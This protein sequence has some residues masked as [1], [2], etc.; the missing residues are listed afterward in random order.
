MATAAYCKR[1]DS[2]DCRCLS[3]GRIALHGLPP[4]A[5][6][7]ET[8]EVMDDKIMR[9]LE[10]EG[11]VEPDEKDDSHVERKSAATQLV[12]IATELYDFGVSDAGET[13]AVPKAG[14]RVLF[15][16]RGGKSSLRAQLSREFFTRTGK[17][18]PQQALADA[19][20][21]VEGMAQEEPESRLYLRVARH[22]GALWL[23]LGDNT[24]RAVKI[25]GDGWTVEKE[26]PVL[27]KRTSLTGPLPV[28]VRGGSLDE[29][30]EW[31]NVAEKDRPLIAAH[32][33]AVLLP[34]IPHVVPLIQ[35]EQ[36]T[37][38]STAEKVLVLVLDPSP[39]PLRK[40]P[41]DVDAWVTAAAGSWVVGL[42]NLSDI[43]PW[44][45]DAICRAVT[46]DGDVRRKLYTDG[47]LAVFAFRRVVI[48]NGIDLGALR[49]DLSDRVLPIDL[50]L[51]DEEE[52]IDEEDLWPKWEEAHPRILGAILDLAAGVAGVLPSVRLE[53]KPRMA[54]FARVVAATDDVLGT[55]GLE[56]YRSRAEEIAADA[57]S[58]DRFAT[59]LKATITEDFEGTSAQLLELVT[60][61]NPKWR[62]PKGWPADARKVTAYLRRIAPTLR[63]T[64]WTVDDLGSHNKEKIVRW[65]ILPPPE[66][67]RDDTRDTRLH[68]QSG[69]D[70]GDGGDGYA[71]SQ[72]DEPSEDDL[73]SSATVQ[74]PTEDL[75]AEAAFA[76][77]WNRSLPQVAIED[78]PTER[79]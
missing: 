54:D 78:I 58:G 39:A 7:D 38:K 69:G 48:V 53:R 74:P 62:P 10:Q 59:Q 43:S 20:L 65:S 22:A 49:G 15:M 41:R 68:P 66:M 42:D 4:D 1:C 76:R 13:F 61:D 60:P 35:G 18:A 21:V 5:R 79:R 12:G 51:I 28:P 30:W 77:A 47:E 3:P 57:L 16:L 45:S 11:V 31:L 70:G 9:E 8:G 75:E 24:G 33:V 37:G 27:F 50:D 2:E 25:T 63:R 64:G 36:G 55:N 26:P 40:V 72:D 73:L 6:P 44:L 14:P 71:P 19:L 67:A 29:L 32:L 17:A 56:R 23:D 34:D 52:R 46:G